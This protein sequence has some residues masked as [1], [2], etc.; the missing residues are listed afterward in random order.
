MF[1]RTSIVILATPAK[2]ELRRLRLFST[3]TSSVQRRHVAYDTNLATRQLLVL[4]DSD[5]PFEF[6]YEFVDQV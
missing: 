2:A 1:V 5:R 3:T 4:F 6:D